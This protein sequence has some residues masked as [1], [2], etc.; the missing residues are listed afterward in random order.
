MEEGK[1]SVSSRCSPPPSNFGRRRPSPLSY[2][3]PPVP[4]FIHSGRRPSPSVGKLEEREVEKKPS[5]LRS[6]GSNLAD[7]S[8][9]SLPLCL[10]GAILPFL[11]NDSYEKCAFSF[12]FLPLRFWS[13][14]GKAFL[15]QAASKGENGA[16]FR[17]TFSPCP[18]RHGNRKSFRS[19]R[20]ETCWH[21]PLYDWK[22][23]VIAKS[24]IVLRRRYCRKD[25]RVTPLP[26]SF[27][28]RR[29]YT[30]FFCE[31]KCC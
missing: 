1:E 10:K 29:S 26:S 8:P 11:Q 21:F 3:P 17:K 30:L 7:Q 12:F 19:G 20:G 25:S 2:P 15:F 9:P 22:A 13:G 18:P 16:T 23:S 28:F 27:H 5:S 4:I 6:G 14:C 24:C 31:G